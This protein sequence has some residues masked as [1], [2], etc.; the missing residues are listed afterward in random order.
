[1]NGF[2]ARFLATY[3]G[4]LTSGSSSASCR[5]TFILQRNAPLPI[6]DALVHEFA[7][8]VPDFSPEY[9]RRRITRLVSYYALFKWWLLLSQ[10][11][12]C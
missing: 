4:I 7:A 12:S 5:D 9:Y 3:A 2:L 11:P 6:T 8:S 1:M 10:H